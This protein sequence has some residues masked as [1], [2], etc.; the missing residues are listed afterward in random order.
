MFLIG[1]NGSGYKY[2]KKDFFA[3]CKQIIKYV[4]DSGKTPLIVT[5]R[6]TKESHEQLIKEHLEDYL[7]VRSVWF[8]SG[9]GRTNLSNIFKL[10][11]E[12]FV[13]EDSSSMIAESISS[14]LHVYTIAPNRQKKNKDYLEMLYRYERMGFI[15]RLNFDT[16]FNN[17]TNK[18]TL[19]AKYKKII[20]A[21]HLLK[22]Q[23]LKKLNKLVLT[24]NLK[25]L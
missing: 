9:I 15:K 3:L 8:N 20:N 10:V 19:S 6:R 7:D 5:S 2:K 11:D 22:I 4:H 1:G 14:G 12:I 23:I 25:I 18:S 21:K 13:T 17:Y 16:T 24:K